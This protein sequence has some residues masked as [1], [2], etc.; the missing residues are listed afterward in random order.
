MLESKIQAAIV[1]SLQAEKIFRHS[2]INEAGGNNIVRTMQFISMGLWAGV[3][4]LII[5]W[6]LVSNY[7]DLEEYPIELGY[8]EVKRPG[9]KQSKKQIKF[10]ARCLRNGVPYIVVYSV[11]DIQAE[12]ARRNLCV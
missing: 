11:E 2:V 4:D 12:L 6:P 1:Q 7:R 8:C 5:W 9:C 10:E 3:A